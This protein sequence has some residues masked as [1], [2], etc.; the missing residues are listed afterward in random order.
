MLVIGLTGGIG[1]GKSTVARLL[2]E[3]GA[4]LVDADQVARQVVEPGSPV[5]A[6]LAER[7]GPD[8]LDAGRL[9]RAAL[10]AVAFADEGARRDLERITHPAIREEMLRQVE[11]AAAADPGAVV[12]LDVP[13]LAE[14]GRHRYPVDGVLVVEAPVDQ[15]IRRL[16]DGRGWAEQDAVARMA[17]QASTEDRRAIADEVIDNS[18]DL[19][20][21]RSEVERAWAWIQSLGLPL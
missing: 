4:V 7:F 9:D 12:V 15:V 19:D 2:V 1:S 20:Q 21:L 3:L 16:T 11:A 14:V 13:L 10:A 5:L 17:A 8:V 6:A 18:G